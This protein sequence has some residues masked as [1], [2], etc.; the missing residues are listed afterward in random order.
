MQ[1][2]L[3]VDSVGL[4]AVFDTISLVTYLAIIGIGIWMVKTNSITIGEFVAFYTYV[5]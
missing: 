1:M 4:W 2:R 3:T 5:E